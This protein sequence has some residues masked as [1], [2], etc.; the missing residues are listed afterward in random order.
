[1]FTTEFYSQLGDILSELK[2]H[3]VHSQ[4]IREILDR[5]HSSIVNWTGPVPNLTDSFQREDVDSIL[6]NIVDHMCKNDDDFHK[7]GVIIKFIARTGYR[8]EPKV[9]RDGKPVLCCTTAIH[10]AFDWRY[11]YKLDNVIRDLFKIYDRYDV[12]YTDEC[13]YTHFHMACLFG[14]EAVVKKFLKFGQD[15]NILVQNTGDSPMHLAVESRNQNIIE[16]LLRGGANPRLANLNGRTPLHVI[17]YGIESAVALFEI[18]DELNQ[19]LQVDARD[20]LGN[21]PLNLAMKKGCRKV[22]ELLLRRGADP[23]LT[24]KRELAPRHVMTIDYNDKYNLSKTLCNVSGAISHVARIDTRD[25]MGN[26]PLHL[27]LYHR[28][29]A[30]AETL[31]RNGAN[32]NLTND[33]GSTALHIIF[34]EKYKSYH[35]DG[36]TKLFF[37]VTD[38]INQPVQ[39]DV[40]DKLGRTPLQLAVANL[41]PNAVDLLLDHGA[42]LSS[43]TFPSESCFATKSYK[44]S[45]MM[46]SWD[47]KLVSRA[48]LVLD[49]IRSSYT[50]V[51]VAMRTSRGRQKR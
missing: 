21:T 33:E 50:D 19:P 18:S 49:S 2:A 16:V 9:D 10:R 5:L 24:N 31:L 29:E 22:A 45:E 43:F 25:N 35:D 47:T 39:V 28:R 44:S 15:P 23:Y 48:M 6:V 11:I 1:M 3:N 14:C 13:G 46:H 37:K 51:G 34:H 7:G 27:A 36:L 4:R 42:S 20:N 40:Q 38:E 8:H 41:M 32:P 30:M 12:N 26:T 17:G